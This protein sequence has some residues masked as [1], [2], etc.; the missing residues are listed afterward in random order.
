VCDNDRNSLAEIASTVG[1]RKSTVDEELQNGLEADDLENDIESTPPSD[2]IAKDSADAV[3]GLSKERD[4]GTDLDALLDKISSIVDCDPKESVSEEIEETN[5]E[6]DDKEQ[7]ADDIDNKEECEAATDSTE[8]AV[9][10]TEEEQKEEAH[11]NNVGAEVEGEKTEL[12]EETKDKQIIA[13]PEKIEAAEVK[14]TIV[15]SKEKAS[16]VK[17]V[18]N[19]EDSTAASDV[20]DTTATDLNTTSDEIFVDALETISSSDEFDAN[21]EPNP[22][23]KKEATNGLEDITSDDSLD[24][25]IPTAAEKPK[26]E[27]AIIDLDTMDDTPKEESAE[28]SEKENNVKEDAMEVDESIEDAKKVDGVTLTATQEL[29]DDAIDDLLTQAAKTIEATAEEAKA[30]TELEKTK[31][32][33]SE[34]LVKSGEGD[35]P[36]TETVTTN[37]TDH[38]VDKQASRGTSVNEPDS[39]ESK[40]ADSDD[41]VIFFESIDKTAN[42][43]EATKSEIAKEKRKAGKEADVVKK[44]DEVVLVSEDED[45]MPPAKKPVEEESG[46]KADPEATPTIKTDAKSKSN[47]LVDNSDNACD[48]FEK[49]R[50]QEKTPP[51]IGAGEDSNSS[52]LLQPS[53]KSQHEVAV[54]AEPEITTEVDQGYVEADEEAEE[55]Y[56][57]AAK[58]IRLSTDDKPEAS[59]SSSCTADAATS[60]T[61]T[62]NTSATNEDEAQPEVAKRNHSASEQKEDIPSKKL[63]TDDTDSNSSC[64]GN[65]Q[66]DLDAHDNAEECETP[67]EPAKAQT[68]E[69]AIELKPAPE[70]KSD[71]KPLRMDFVKGFRK[72]FDKM[73]RAD[74]EELVLQKV[75]EAMLV[76]SDFAEIRRLVD[77]QEATLANYRRKIAE[78]SKQFLDLETVHK[79]VLKDLETRNSHFTAPVRITRAVGL[80]VGM[81]LMKKP[82]EEAATR[83]QTSLHTAG[84]MPAPAATS[85]SVAS[86]STQPASITSQPQRTSTSP[87]GSV[88]RSPLRGMTRAGPVMQQSAAQQQQLHQQQLQQQQQQ[89]YSAAAVGNA[90]PPVRRGCMQKV[91]PQRPVNNSTQSSSGAAGMQR[92]Q[93]SPGNTASRVYATKHTGNSSAATTT[94]AATAAVMRSR[95]AVSKPAGA[96]YMTAK[97][98]MQQQH[99]RIGRIPGK[100]NN[101]KTRQ[102]PMGGGTVSVPMSNA[103]VDGAGAGYG[104]PSL[105]P[106]RPKEKAVIDLTDED[107][108]AAAAAAEVTARLRQNPNV[109]IKRS[110]QSAAGG[111]GNARPVAGSV[112]R[113][114]PMNVSRSNAVSRQIF[115]NNSAGQRNS[116]GANVTM[117]IRSENTPPSPSRLRFSHPAPLPLA[118]AQTFHPDWK[119]PPSRPVIR[120]S[121]HD[122]GIVISWTLEDTGSRFAECVTYQI[123]AYQETSNEPSTDSWRHVG[124]VKAMLLPM[125]VTLNQFQEN[126]RYFFAVRGVDAHDRYGVFSLPKTW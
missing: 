17:T 94:A 31:A 26:A 57:P 71:V 63:K 98:L 81:T 15:D 74:L 38:K 30:T 93:T 112:V 82:S 25:E 65:L 79:R 9:I 125:A 70:L 60:T 88:Q 35:L 50:A 84:S 75:V 53:H 61:N 28:D 18:E 3:R 103:T 5:L 58:R 34:D 52:N 78:V 20:S 54:E 49:Q 46:K 95:G 59:N 92:L 108:A 99:V 72:T 22:S 69:P 117:Q 104:Q 51:K 44:E 106:A 101:A 36:A 96:A 109:G 85:S 41:E 107:D 6:T 12:S 7:P 32:K 90:T 55:P 2:S 122:T 76:K 56:A 24:K 126:Q 10:D 14:E 43:T 33:E 47:L 68:K 21:P 102:M 87:K 11:E 66:I 121:L 1:S 73:T 39:K 113:V 83:N 91:T 16:E 37:E 77:K 45:E 27:P 123:Y 23:P 118:P 8:A 115:N 105:A 42:E 4:A 62:T 29:R 86:T 111:A 119:L 67:A 100:P 89:R 40:E 97:Q 114:S 80:Q 124:D 13:Q 19:P 110:A 120:I 64:D 48:Q 116:V